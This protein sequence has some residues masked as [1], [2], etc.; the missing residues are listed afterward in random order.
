MLARGGQTCYPRSPLLSAI[1]L[2]P[3]SHPYKTNEPARWS[4]SHD[5]KPAADDDDETDEDDDD[6]GDDDDED[7][8]DEEDDDDDNDDYDCNHDELDVA[9]DASSS[10]TA[11]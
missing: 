6:H 11:Y 2:V 8:E 7:V 5:N 1:V 4:Y 10:R 9:D 3:R